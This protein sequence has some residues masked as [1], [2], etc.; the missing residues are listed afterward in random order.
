[1]LNKYEYHYRQ[2]RSKGLFT[3]NDLKLQVIFAKDI[4][5]YYHDMLWPSGMC[6]YLDAKHFIH[7]RNPTDQVKAYKNFV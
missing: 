2:T 7:K 3:E 4:K 1:M 5:K 6:L